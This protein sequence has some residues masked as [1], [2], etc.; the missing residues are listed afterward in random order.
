MITQQV[1]LPKWGTTMQEAYIAKILVAIGDSVSK[2]QVL[3]SIETDKVAIE[4][5]SPFQGV[6][7]D[8]SVREGDVVSVGTVLLTVNVL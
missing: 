6:V 3:V 7:R 2:G 1:R 8:I 4:V 5:E